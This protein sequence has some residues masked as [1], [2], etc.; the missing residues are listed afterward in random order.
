VVSQPESVQELKSSARLAARTGERGQAAQ[1]R[2][3]V[4]GREPEDPAGYLG[5]AHALEYS[6]RLD[7]AERLLTKAV[8]R[9]PTHAPAA[10]ASA[11][12]ANRRRLWPE[13]LRRWQVVRE[14][15]PDDAAGFL[16][17]ANA[18]R[19][20]GHLA[21]AEALLCEAVQRFP[22]HEA[23]AVAYAS[24][25]SQRR[26]WP[27]AL[28]RWAAVKTKFPKNADGF[29]GA[30]NALRAAG[31]LDEA[32]LLL[33][34]AAR[35][36]PDHAGIAVAGAAAASERR[37][38]A[39]ALARWDRVR[40]LLPNQVQAYLG[41]LDAL[42]EMG[43]L[44]E[45]AT[46]LGAAQEA[47]VHARQAGRDEAAADRLE[48][49]IARAGKN[50]PAVRRIIERLLAGQAYPS[51]RLY[52]QLAFACRHMNDRQSAEAAAR[53]A[54]A[55]DPN[56]ESAVLIIA[57][58]ATEAGDGETALRHYRE[59]ARIAPDNPRWAFE[60]MRLLYFMGRLGEAWDELQRARHR[61][62]NDPLFRIWMLNHGLHEPPTV[63]AGTRDQPGAGGLAHL[64][65]EM[66]ELI[67]AAPRDGELRRAVIADDR[68]EDVII[69]DA[70]SGAVAVIIFT[71]PHDHVTMP[72]PVFDRYLA[73][74]GV[75]AIY[76]KDFAR[77]MY[78]RG[79]RS[80][81][82]ADAT[83]AALRSLAQSL[84]ADRTCAIGVA[85]AA[86]IRYGVQLEADRIV[87]FGAPTSRAL[88]PVSAESVRNII[89]QRLDRE[90]S[91]FERNLKGF[92]ESRRCSSKIE[93]V[94]AEG[95]AIDKA[96][97][98]H[99]AGLPGVTLRPQIGTG[100]HAVLRWLAK[101]RQL[102]ATLA[103]LTGMHGQG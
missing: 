16:G 10:I 1:Q 101:R 88:A 61:W 63:A 5:A 57:W 15:F 47:L 60:A 98:E 8:E 41:I 71:G 91:G 72:L 24:L 21:E 43:R 89:A 54:L 31:R 30:A 68:D 2:E 74:L 37:D 83:L 92:L 76:L 9:F 13:A 26:D 45:A 82:D 62:P 34:E 39:E 11:A 70:G 3:Q 4:L 95:M 28:H 38:W 52:L 93:L 48:L 6:G 35:R 77:L 94:Y 81:G 53:R 78:R 97:A 7:E 64:E 27:E 42:N 84:G 29:L 40:R 96:H 17:K 103:E 32:E 51:A 23:I 12:L 25:A 87:C 55:L 90:L 86:A 56:L 36:F 75:T 100:D 67:E 19:G 33:S 20:A 18:L 65:Q 99:L 66:R 14:R 46:L 73:A 49:A 102:S 85:T 59:L 22:E 44:E 80:L 69:G 50:W 58:A 79:V